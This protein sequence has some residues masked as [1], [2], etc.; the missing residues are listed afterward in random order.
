MLII[1]LLITMIIRG[2]ED[3]SDSPPHREPVNEAAA[4]L[5]EEGVG[6][7]GIRIAGVG[8]NDGVGLLAAP[9]AAHNEQMPR[10]IAVPDQ[11]VI[12]VTLERRRVLPR[13][14]DAPIALAVARER[15]R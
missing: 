2:P 8:A 4:R 1:L 10:I 9:P 12:E 14:P 6:S 13:A 7:D 3:S 11:L 15:R 5:L